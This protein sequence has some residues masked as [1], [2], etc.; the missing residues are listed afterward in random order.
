MSYRTV[1]MLAAIVLVFAFQSC[2]KK[3]TQEELH[4]QAQA[5]EQEEDYAEALKS[6]KKLLEN[7]PEGDSADVAVRKIA[8]LYYNNF[9][10][11]EK[12]IEYHRKL[13]EDYPES[14]SVPQSRFMI[15]YI[16]ANNLN[17]YDKA[18]EA[19]NEFLKHHP[20]N[21]LV[22]SVK[23]ELE[24]LGQDINQQLKTLFG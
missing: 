10:E 7:Y 3:Q 21:E 2:G 5:Y 22:E 6:Y 1:S 12:A 13:I 20:E 23:W 16:Y 9:P 11:Y 8:F 24:H 15:G 17:E 4:N 18:K 14:E 19:Y